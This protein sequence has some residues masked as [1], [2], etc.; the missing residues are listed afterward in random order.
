MCVLR[1]ATVCVFELQRFDIV[2]T[3]WSWWRDNGN[4]WKCCRCSIYI[5]SLLSI[6]I[7]TRQPTTTTR[8][9]K[10]SITQHWSDL[11]SKQQPTLADRLVGAFPGLVDGEETNGGDVVEWL[12]AELEQR[13]IEQRPF[14]AAD[15]GCEVI[16]GV[17]RHDD[18]CFIELDVSDEQRDDYGLEQEYFDKLQRTRIELL[19]RPSWPLVCFAVSSAF[20]LGALIT[21]V[22]LSL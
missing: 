8:K 7:A 22:A 4:G 1:T 13:P 12:S 19:G 3:A 17:T 18:G 6:V 20:I 16:D 10:M 15:C 9:Q 5:H 2:T 21:C 11:A 14:I